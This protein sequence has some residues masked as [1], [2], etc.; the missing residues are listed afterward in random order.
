MA[1]R[2]AFR[3]DLP[4]G[5]CAGLAIPEALD[6]ADLAA[7]AEGERALAAAMPPARGRLFAA[8][9]LA[10]RSALADAGLAVDGPILPDPRGAPALPPGIAGSISHKE[11][12]AVGLAAPAGPEADLAVGVDIERIAPLRIDISRR[13]LTDAELAELQ[14]LPLDERNERIL[15]TLSAKEALYKALDRFVG[16]YVSFKEAAVAPAPDGSTSAALALVNGEGPFEVDI[17]WRRLDGFFVTT[18]RV[19]RV[20]N[21]VVKL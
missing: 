20:T 18:A 2:L 10:L 13:V 3:L 5:R 9:R 7:L 6:A 15:L 16:R 14:A 21:R 12:L 19:R 1:A 17:R 11:E 4:H 8:G